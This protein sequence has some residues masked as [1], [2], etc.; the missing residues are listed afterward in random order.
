MQP[1]RTEITRDRINN[2][3]NTTLDSLQQSMGD[4]DPA[5][6]VERFGEKIPTGILQA[7][8]A[9]TRQSK[10]MVNRTVEDIEKKIEKKN[11]FI[12][13]FKEESMVAFI[14]LKHRPSRIG[15]QNKVVSSPRDLNISQVY[16][17]PLFRRKGI[18]KSMVQWVLRVGKQAGCVPRGMPKRGNVAMHGLYQQLGFTDEGTNG[19]GTYTRYSSII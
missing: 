9:A 7:I 6:R 16:V 19:R 15:L 17:N 3:V 4:I 18:A 13:V 1:S 5:F 8:S 12:V 2:V 10:Y 11:M 14:I